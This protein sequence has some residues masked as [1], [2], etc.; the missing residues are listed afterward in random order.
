MELNIY[1]ITGSQPTLS[2]A[3]VSTWSC[4]D[5]RVIPEANM[6]ICLHTLANNYN[7][8]GCSSCCWEIKTKK[9]PLWTWMPPVWEVLGAAQ[10][11]GL[12]NRVLAEL[13]P[14]DLPW[15]TIVSLIQPQ[16]HYGLIYSMK[17]IIIKDFGPF[18]CPMLIYF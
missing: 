6:M 13:L 11:Y 9:S 2:P 12:L 4:S 17:E 15:L 5:L 18:S 7:L 14:I 16:G 8:S 10:P 3:S 1:I